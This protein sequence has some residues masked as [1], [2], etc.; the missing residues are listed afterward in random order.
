MEKTWRFFRIPELFDCGGQIN[1]PTYFSKRASFSRS[2]RILASLGNT[3][4]AHSL[5]FIRCGSPSP[6]LITIQKFLPG[7]GIH[8]RHQ[9]EQRH[10]ST[11]G[12]NGR[13]SET[14][15]QSSTSQAG[16]S[17]L[18]RSSASWLRT[19]VYGPNVQTTGNASSKSPRIVLG[20]FGRGRRGGVLAPLLIPLGGRRFLVA[21]RRRAC[22]CFFRLLHRRRFRVAVLVWLPS[23]L[24]VHVCVV[25]AAARGPKPKKRLR[26][27]ARPRRTSVR[28]P[29]RTPPRSPDRTACPSS[30]RALPV[31]RLEN[32]SR[33]THDPTSSRRRRPPRR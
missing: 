26:R 25:P 15:S 17:H 8:R 7:T 33:D 32:A 24:T 10:T 4:R 9:A 23:L 22:A 27:R 11:S 6:R 13:V 5:T 1:G 28:D 16:V 19:W 31:Q 29:R 30:A 3:R 14:P 20:R 18:N 2:S 21:A 12:L